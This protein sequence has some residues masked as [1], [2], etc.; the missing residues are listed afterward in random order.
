VKEPS[1]SGTK[2]F[3][4]YL[5]TVVLGAVV[6][7]VICVVLLAVLSFIFVSSALIPHDFLTALIIF[8]TALS[9]FF[10][11]LVAAKISKKHGLICG[12]MSGLVLFALFLLAGLITEKSGV[13]SGAA[14]RLGIM[15]NWRLNCR[16]QESKIVFD[17]LHFA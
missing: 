11:G 4:I 9:A 12:A 10:A 7:A 13:S 6:G 2:G 16:K 5:R 15:R 8:I 1:A 14:S 17:L 3:L